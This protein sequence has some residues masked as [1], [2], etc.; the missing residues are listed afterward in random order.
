M[1]VV[2]VVGQQTVYQYSAETVYLL[3]GNKKL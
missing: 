2:L 1:A 3:K